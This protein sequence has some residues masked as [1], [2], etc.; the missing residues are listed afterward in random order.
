MDTKIGCFMEPEVVDAETTVQSRFKIEA[1]KLVRER[2][3]S[4]A[5]TERGDECFNRVKSSPD[6]P[7]ARLSDAIGIIGKSPVGRV[8]VGT[9]GE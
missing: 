2:G 1:V 6:G 4:A 9:I 7:E 8:K 3:V 5:Q